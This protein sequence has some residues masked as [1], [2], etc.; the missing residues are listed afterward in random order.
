[1]P[2]SFNMDYILIR[3]STQDEYAEFE[4]MYRYCT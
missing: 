3:K 2:D 1:L 4:L